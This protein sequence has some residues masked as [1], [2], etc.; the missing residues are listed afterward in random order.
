MGESVDGILS[1]QWD[2]MLLPFLLASDESEADNQLKHLLVDVAV[3]V[4]KPIVRSSIGTRDAQGKRRHESQ[5]VEDVTS[6]T[7]VRL[8][9]T[10]RGLRRQAGGVNIS[11]FINYVIIITHHACDTYLRFKYPN[12][13]RLARAL[14]YAMNRS[15]QFAT[16]REPDGRWVCGLAQ[17]RSQRSVVQ[18]GWV[19]QALMEPDRFIKWENTGDIDEL[20]RATFN[21]AQAPL[22]IDD[23]VILAADIL[24]VTDEPV[25][26]ADYLRSNHASL[27][28][29][30]DDPVDTAAQRLLLERVWKWIVS[31]PLKQRISLLLAAKDETKTSIAVLLTEIRVASLGEI[32]G[33]VGMSTDAFV[34]LL[35]ELPLSDSAIGKRLNIGRRKIQSS[36]LS[37]RRRLKRQLKS[38]K[39][40]K[41]CERAPHG[42]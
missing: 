35:P 20:L 7:V 10:L 9:D 3:P 11:N 19:N 27:A 39:D 37:G 25:S 16:W 21:G 22:D 36:R 8:L 38:D 29:E 41:T 18:P 14:R 32:G 34:R 2:S 12:R 15:R 17:W 31:L 30:F 5:D 40:E 28:V 4:I 13:T 23:V 26:I 6:E 24:K 42:N 33:A 1:P